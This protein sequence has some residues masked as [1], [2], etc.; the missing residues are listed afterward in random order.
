MFAVKSLKLRVWVILKSV[1]VTEEVNDVIDVPYQTVAL[2]DSFAPVI[3]ITAV[4]LPTEDAAITPLSGAV[5][6]EIFKRNP[7]EATLPELSVALKVIFQPP[8]RFLNLSV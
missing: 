3:V 6:S 1:S 5:L 7:K 4:V 2:T 8:F